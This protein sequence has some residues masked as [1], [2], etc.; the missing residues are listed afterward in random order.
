[1][2]ERT[3]SKAISQ[4]YLCYSVDGGIQLQHFGRESEWEFWVSQEVCW[5]VLPLVFSSVLATTFN[6]SLVLIE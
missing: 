2:N 4:G 5:T 3:L 1:M 6:L